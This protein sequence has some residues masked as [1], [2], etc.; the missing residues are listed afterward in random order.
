MPT[1]GQI[2][3]MLLE[4]IILQALRTAGYDTVLAPDGIRTFNGPSGL[5][6]AGKA[7]RH[8]IDA[9]ADYCFQPPFSHPQRL[10]VEAKCYV[11]NVQLDVIRN[12]VGVHKDLS[13]A[14]ATP[15]AGNQ[16][17]HYQYA[18]F[19][20]SEFSN[21][22]EAYAFAHDVYLFP[23]RRSGFFQPI[24]RAIWRARTRRL[25]VRRRRAQ[26]SMTEL[27]TRFR[28]A[29][30]SGTAGRRELNARLLDMGADGVLDEVLDAASQ[31]NGVL[32]A[33]TK[34]GFLVMLVPEL[35]RELL[36]VL[37]SAASTPI[38]IRAKSLRRGWCWVVEGRDGMRLFTLDIPPELFRRFVVPDG[39]LDRRAFAD[40]KATEFGI[41]QVPYRFGTQVGLERLQLDP[42]WIEEVRQ[43]LQNDL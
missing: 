41:L 12:A 19:S 13:E 2:R 11:D 1:G 24:I 39:S 15:L 6:I 23:L 42:E 22:A 21:A 26:I 9:V 34:S 28:D 32:F 17:Y 27:R 29:L 20:A 31:L 7:T 43:G 14:W 18:V 38:R 25:E 8:Q 35:G 16:R 4:E 10:L 33:S 37:Q 3:G 40:T 36:E 5:E 30:E